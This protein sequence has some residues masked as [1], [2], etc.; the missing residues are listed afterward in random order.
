MKNIVL[1]QEMV[2]ATGLSYKK[3]CEVLALASK[4]VPVIDFFVKSGKGYKGYCL[5]GHVS[6]LKAMFLKDPEAF[7]ITI[8]EE[9]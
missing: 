3:A 9:S 6:A 5:C 4:K 2:F 7:V 1:F 8:E